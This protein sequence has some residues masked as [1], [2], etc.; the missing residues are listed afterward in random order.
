[1]SASREAHATLV[2]T[3]RAHA[4]RRPDTVAVTFLKDGE[5]VGQRLTYRELDRQARGVAG[6]LQAVARAGERALLLFENNIDFVVAFL[7]CLYAQVIAIPAYP[8]RSNHHLKR[9]QALVEDAQATIVLVAASIQEHIGERAARLPV[10]DSARWLVVRSEDDALADAWRMPDLRADTLAFLQ[11][12]SGSTGAPKGVMVSHGNLVHNERLAQV[13]FG[14]SEDSVLVGWL[15]L[16]HDMG[17]I[18][19]VLQPLYVGAASVLMSP[20]AFIQKPVRWL[21][22]IADHGGRNV[23]SGAPNFAYDL[24]VRKITDES[25]Q[26]L[27]LSGWQVAFNGAEPVRAEVLDAFAERFAPYG[28]RRTALYPCYGMA[29][30][31]LLISS[32]ERSTEPIYRAVDAAALEQGRCEDVSPGKPSRRLV[33]CGRTWL[34]QEL[35]VVDPAT[36]TPC[37]PRQ[38]G[39]IWLSGGSVALGYWNRPEL[40]RETFQARLPD[41]GD[42]TFLRTGDL[43]FLDGSQLYVTGRLKDLIII[44]GRNHY[45]QDIEATVAQ[46]SHMLHPDGGA[47]F[48]IEGPDGEELVVVHEVERAFWRKID[49]DAVAGQIRQ[50]VSETHEL[51]VHAV[52]LLPPNRLPKTSSGKT[53]RSACRAAFLAGTLDPLYQWV[54]PAAEPAPAPEPGPSS[55]AAAGPFTAERIQGWLVEQMAARLR[56]PPGEIDP[57]QPMAHYGLDSALAVSL[58]NDLGGWLGM[59]LEPMVFWEYPS[60]EQLSSHLAE[61]TR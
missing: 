23:T 22:A 12:T 16:F 39:E 55:R 47:A 21:R 53:Q 48:S 4:E 15:P 26:G 46:C 7:G 5:Q 36:G 17:L 14:H 25:L 19:K 51:M 54:A 1:M 57:A 59:E 6:R 3:I 27:D 42:R 60:I 50:A 41:S 40:T 33:S 45:P 20:A 35:R 8:P 61:K 34:E 29:E 24:C 9:L 32:N 30:A 13:A 49:G 10:L 18:G 31:T 38:V 28:L 52:V 56:L 43:G 37:P 11:Y 44:R 58:I 2:H